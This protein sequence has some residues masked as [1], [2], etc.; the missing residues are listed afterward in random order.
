MRKEKEN[1]DGKQLDTQ[2]V[3]QFDLQTDEPEGQRDTGK[4]KEGSSSRQGS[5]KS[6]QNQRL[7][8]TKSLILNTRKQ[9]MNIST[10]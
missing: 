8:K 5:R 4:P 1:E 9:I 2:L 7:Q 3:K 6:T 10:E